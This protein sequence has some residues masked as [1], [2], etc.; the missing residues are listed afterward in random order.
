MTA[1]IARSSILLL[2][3]HVLVWSLEEGPRLGM[4]CKQLINQAAH[5]NKLVL[6][7][8]TPWE[9][10][11]LVSKG[12]LN[13]SRDV[14]DWMDLALSKPGLTLIPLAPAIAVSSTRLPFEMHSDPADR[15]L[16]A[17]ARQL[18][19]TLVTADRALLALGEA[20]NYRALNA[21]Q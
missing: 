20:G 9:I 13:L 15:I 7:A 17:T 3:T 8:I 18:G 19:A 4:A 12:R 14:M 16:V 5:Q 1:E 10:A 21:E 11:L 6:S 2:D